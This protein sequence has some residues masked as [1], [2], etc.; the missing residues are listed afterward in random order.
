MIDLKNRILSGRRFRGMKLAGE[1]PEGAGIIP[2]MGKPG[3]DPS[4]PKHCAAGGGRKGYHIT[5]RLTLSAGAQSATASLGDFFT[6]A[7]SGEISTDNEIPHNFVSEGIRFNI[8]GLATA[9]F[10]ET[11]AVLAGLYIIEKKQ[12]IEVARYDVMSL[13]GIHSIEGLTT[14][15]VGNWKQTGALPLYEWARSYDTKETY[16]LE[17]WN[18]LAFTSVA[19]ISVSATLVGTR[20]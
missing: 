10:V 3:C 14:S 16:G 9:S 12:S 17:L 15:G 1:A 19:D 2:R 5:S 18:T 4:C 13:L 7:A 6:A 20:S 11:A 8:S